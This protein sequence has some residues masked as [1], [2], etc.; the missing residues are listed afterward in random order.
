M[1][2]FISALGLKVKFLGFCSTGEEWWARG[3][4]LFQVGSVIVPDAYLL[5]GDGRLWMYQILQGPS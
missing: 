3:T 5:A 2:L 4:F 1:V